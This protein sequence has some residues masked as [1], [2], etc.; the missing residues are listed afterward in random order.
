MTT[1]HLTAETLALIA[2]IIIALGVIGRA[3]WKAFVVANG[4]YSILKEIHYEITPD[5]GDSVHDIIERND[6]NHLIAHRNAE[7]I[8]GVV[9]KFHEVDAQDVPLLEVPETKES[10][11]RRRERNSSGTENLD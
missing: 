8:Y 1:L 10:Q 5:G 3:A 9:L 6:M 11:R 7:A 4:I 2:G